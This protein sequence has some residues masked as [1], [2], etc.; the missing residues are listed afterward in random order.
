MINQY[1]KDFTSLMVFTSAHN[2]QDALQLRYRELLVWT[3][4]TTLT[5]NSKASQITDIYR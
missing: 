2:N 4:I 1:L 3:F 5:W